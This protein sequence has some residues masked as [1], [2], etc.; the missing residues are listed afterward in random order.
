M[1]LPYEVRCTVVYTVVDDWYHAEGAALVRGRPGVKPRFS[2]SEV[3]TLVM[4]RALEG[5]TRE[6]RWYRMVSANWRG[7]FPQLPERSVLYKRTK[8][9]WRLLD[10][11]RCRLRD[12]LL[13]DDLRRP[14]DGTPVPVRAISRVGRPRGRSA[15]RH[16]AQRTRHPPAVRAPYRPAAP[17]ARGR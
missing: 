11:C 2:D 3:L 6:R 15:G 5:Q 12:R 9:L 16:F 4:V 13:T 8:S 17:P 14:I 1:D 10:R 7:L